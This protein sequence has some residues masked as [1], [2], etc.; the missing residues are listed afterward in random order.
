[1]GSLFDPHRGEEKV[2]VTGGKK[3]NRRG[4]IGWLKEFLEPWLPFVKG[5]TKE[6]WYRRNGKTGWVERGDG[7]RKGIAMEKYDFR[8]NYRSK[9]TNLRKR[10]ES[11]GGTSRAWE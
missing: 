1:L 9:K 10:N 5:T 4:E 7:G 6:E 2:F 11:G 8:H 3:G